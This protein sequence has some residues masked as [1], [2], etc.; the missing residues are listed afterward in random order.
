MGWIIFSWNSAAVV[1]PMIPCRTLLIRFRST[2]SR[3]LTARFGLSLCAWSSSWFL[4]LESRLFVRFIVGIL[5]LKAAS[6]EPGAFFPA[7]G[8]LFK[9]SVTFFQAWSASLPLPPTFSSLA[10]YRAFTQALFGWQAIADSTFCRFDSQPDSKQTLNSESP[11]PPRPACSHHWKR[12]VLG[13]AFRTL[14]DPCFMRTH[15]RH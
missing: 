5:R 11:S 1:A 3:C 10:D 7:P 12:S 6:Q 15:L 4:A 13:F 14:F 9:V 8:A 2:Q